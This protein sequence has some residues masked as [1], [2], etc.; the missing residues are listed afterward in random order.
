MRLDIH[1]LAANFF[2]FYIF[3]KYFVFIYQEEKA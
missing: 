3:S 1:R 2:F